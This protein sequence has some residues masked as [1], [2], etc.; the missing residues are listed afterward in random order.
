[1]KTLL[2]PISLFA[3]LGLVA[4]AASCSSNGG[5]TNT[6]TAVGKSMYQQLGGADGVTKLANQFG[7]N[8]QSNPTL[9]SIID[10]VALGDIKTGLTNDIMKASGMQPS[11]ATT[12]AS[13]LSGKS[14]DATAVNALSN[15]LKEA[16]ASLGLDPTLTST[17]ASTVVEPAARSAAGM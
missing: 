3:V 6:A 13:A 12:L 1:M 7:A 10:A 8:I 9:N 4:L 2:R 11:S 16:G 15:S 14:L 5:A 17:I